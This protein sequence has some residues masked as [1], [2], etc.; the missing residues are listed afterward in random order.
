MPIRIKK[1]I[2]TV[3]LILLVVIYALLA[4]LI[5]VAQ[6]A[7]SHWLTHL[8]FFLFSGLL[9]ILPAMVIIKW[10]VGPQPAKE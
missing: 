3:L 9:W 7:E 4:T 6:L 8:A 5:A 2:G 10:M 1:L